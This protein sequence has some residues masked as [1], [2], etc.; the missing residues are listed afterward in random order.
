MVSS[1]RRAWCWK[2][3]FERQEPRGVE[4]AGERL[5]EEQDRRLGHQRRAKGDL[6]LL[7]GR[8]ASG[9]GCRPAR[10][11]SKRSEQLIDVLHQP[12]VL[13]VIEPADGQEELAAGP[14]RR[15]ARA[16]RA[17]RPIILR[18]ASS[19]STEPRRVR[20]SIRT[21]APL[22]REHAGHDAQQGRLA[23]AVG[24]EDHHDLAA[25]DPQAD[26]RGAPACTP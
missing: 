9:S 18:M 17:D 6:L 12:L 22:R 14:L 11:R 8:V 2:I 26:A 19:S 10:R 23:H 21:V 3:R 25:L 4:P 20:P 1:L 7:A 13:D 24:A 5:V 16:D 15:E